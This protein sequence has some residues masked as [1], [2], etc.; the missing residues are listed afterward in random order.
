MTAADLESTESLLRLWSQA[1]SRGWVRGS[2]HERLEFIASAVHA[3]RFGVK[4]PPGLFVSRVR[5]HRRSSLTLADEDEARRLLRESEERGP[6]PSA[7]LRSHH[8]EPALTPEDVRLVARISTLAMQRGYSG[9][10]FDLVRSKLSGWTQSRWDRATQCW[11]GR[12]RIS[13]EDDADRLSD[14]GDVRARQH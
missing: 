7:P 13:I 11:L 8:A 9:N 10:L 12:R 6:E 5:Q 2:D 4:N 14:D 3:R 1:C